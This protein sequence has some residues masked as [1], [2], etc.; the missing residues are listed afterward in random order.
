MYSNDGFVALAEPLSPKGTTTNDDDIG[1]FRQVDSGGSRVRRVPSLLYRVVCWPCLCFCPSGR[2]RSPAE[3]HEAPLYLETTVNVAHK[4]PESPEWGGGAA[5]AQENQQ[6]RP[7][8]PDFVIPGTGLESAIAQ[9]LSASGLGGAPDEDECI[10]CLDVFTARQPR[11]PTLCAC[12][13]GKVGFHHACLLRW[14]AAR[15]GRPTCP[16]CGDEL[17]FEV[18]EDQGGEAEEGEAE[19]GGAEEGGAEGRGKGGGESEGRGGG[20]NQVGAAPDGHGSSDNA[21]VSAAIVHAHN[22]EGRGSGGD[23][24]AAG[25]GGNGGVFRHRAW[26][27]E[28]SGGGD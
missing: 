12:G 1:S 23:V 10:V 8:E 17:F 16:T 2:S 22:V 19:G 14:I 3:G 21:A 5:S 18:P 24:D 13:V 4:S 27:D 6:R 28:G 15:Q 26:S 20:G 25:S 9:T 11:L 7:T